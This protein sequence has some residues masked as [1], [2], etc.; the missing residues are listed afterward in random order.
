[1]ILMKTQAGLQVLKDR[2]VPLTPMQRT[3]FILFDGKRSVTEVL[4]STSGAG[5]TRA[6]VDQL[7]ALGLLASLQP[8]PEAVEPVAARTPQER[9][10][11]AYPIA[12]QLTAGLGL[13]GVRLNLAV[14][15]AR[16]YEDLLAVA[17]R[18]REAVGPEKYAPLAQAL[19][20]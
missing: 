13:R 14:E 2:S 10:A 7:C 9:Y 19:E 16:S 20:G 12:T 18:I 4:K 5:V 3:A 15:G 8:E 1:M 11:A 6:D 17:D